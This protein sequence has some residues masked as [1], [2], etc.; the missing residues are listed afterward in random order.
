M[1]S[2][3]KRVG[4]DTVRILTT[5]QGPVDLQNVFVSLP[6]ALGIILHTKHLH[7][8]HIHGASQR[9]IDCNELCKTCARCR[10][11]WTSDAFCSKPSSR[12][13]D[14]SH[15]CDLKFIRRRGSFRASFTTSMAINMIGGSKEDLTLRH[16]S[17][18]F[19][20]VPSH[21]VRLR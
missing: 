1:R 12:V 5:L 10:Y 13:Q 17:V 7:D 19:V 21:L 18:T 20:L 6:T 15:I 14:T 2:S 4:P 9:T 11:C 8:H 3:A 16:Q